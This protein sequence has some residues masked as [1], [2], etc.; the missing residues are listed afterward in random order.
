[1]KGEKRNGLMS[2]ESAAVLI[3]RGLG[4]TIAGDESLLKQLPRGQW[5]GGTT[6]YFM[7]SEGGQCRRDVVFV[8]CLDT[9]DVAVA[10]YDV[11]ILA[12]VLEDAP[13]NGYSI[14]ILPAG[15]PVLEVYAHHAPDFP[16]MFIKPIV[17]WVSGVHLDDLGNRSAAVLDGSSGELHTDQAVVLHVRLP[18]GR[19]AMVHTVN[20]FEAGFG[21]ELT[22]GA[23]G[24]APG[25]CRVDGVVGNLAEVIAAQEIGPE[26]PL[27]ADYCGA[28]VNVSIQS[29][30][31]SAGRV[32]LYAPVFEGVPYRFARPVADY[33]AK[34][35]AAMPRHSG[36]LVFGCN[37]ILNYLHSGLKGRKTAQLTGP[38]TFG[39]VAYQLMNQTA[40]FLTV[41]GDD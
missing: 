32:N 41:E 17:G 26:L 1:M 14:I 24:D 2:V 18:E 23:T 36:N 13:E 29:I 27:V 8:Q 21:P 19:S 30:D 16:D 40:V 3:E 38:I 15:S 12:N 5:I 6:P 34:F 25:E 11:E 28:V 4:L 37:C 9:M 39:E 31:E 33:P 20:L 35:I 7:T 22:F 10:R